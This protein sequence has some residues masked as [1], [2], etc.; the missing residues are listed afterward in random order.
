[1]PGPEFCGRAHFQLGQKEGKTNAFQRFQ[2]CLEQQQLNCVSGVWREGWFEG[3]VRGFYAR[4]PA[5]IAKLLCW[6]VEAWFP[7]EL[8]LMISQLFPFAP[9][10]VLCHS[11]PARRERKKGCCLIALR[12]A[13]V[14]MGIMKER[15]GGRAGEFLHTYRRGYVL[16]SRLGILTV[17]SAKSV[18]ESRRRLWA[19]YVGVRSQTSRAALRWTI[20]TINGMEFEGTGKVASSRSGGLYKSYDIS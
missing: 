18:S 4:F 11:C 13:K 15:Q 6:A 5:S 20:I 8:V 16:L 9:R 17:F 10:D 12:E 2:R 19:N 3:L 14:H 7:N 1:V